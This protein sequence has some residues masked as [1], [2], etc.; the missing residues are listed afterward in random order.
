MS[1]VAFVLITACLQTESVSPPPDP[2]AEVDMSTVD[3]SPLSRDYPCPAENLYVMTWNLEWFPKKGRITVEYVAKAIS[4]MNVDVL[5]IQEI[6]DTRDFERLLD[7]LPGYSG[8][9]ESEWFAG[10]AYIYRSDVVE[11]NEIY[12]IYSTAPY[13]NAFPRSPMVMDMKVAGERYLLINNHLKCCGDGLLNIDDE[14]DEET[15]R[16]DAVLLLQAYIDSHYSSEKLLLL[17]DLND[18]IVEAAPH[19]V[20]QSLLDAPLQYRFADQAIAEG[21]Y[22]EW[23]FPYWPSHL[24]HILLTAPLFDA[25]E[26]S[27]VFT[28][29]LDQYLE[30]GWYEYDKNISDHRPVGLCLA[31]P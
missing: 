16:R 1:F 31:S 10:L 30:E 26:L 6:D 3:F 12:E 13:W 11:I 27:T 8:Y 24:D 20:F 23:S 15:R 17:G 22:T 29:K 21:A 25:L 14:Y 7:L 4:E 5:A 18:N 2:G 19:N 28:I 9:Y